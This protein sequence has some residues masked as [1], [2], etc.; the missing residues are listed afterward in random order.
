MIEEYYDAGGDHAHT[1]LGIEKEAFAGAAFNAAKTIIPRLATHAGKAWGASKAVAPAA[2]AVPTG[3][4]GRAWQATGGRVTEALGKAWRPTGGRVWNAGKTFAAPAGEA[5]E[6]G[7]ASGAGK[8]LGKPGSEMAAKLVKGVP[9]QAAKDA[10]IF[11]GLSAGLE[12]GVG[13]YAAEDGDRLKAFGEGAAHGAMSGAAMGGLMGG[14]GKGFR[15]L[16]S[17]SMQQAAGRQLAKPLAQ[18]R[19]KGFVGPL[20]PVQG[21]RLDAAGLAQRQTA[22][23]QKQM[24]RGFF[25]SVGD[26]ATGKGPINRATSAQNVAGGLG[27]FG[28]EWLAPMA[29]L[30]ASMGGGNPFKAETWGFG[31]TSANPAATDFSPETTAR[32]QAMYQRQGRLPPATAKT[33]E[34]IPGVDL[35]GIE[36]E[37]LKA[38]VRLLTTMGGGAATGIPV[39]MGID[40]L[41]KKP[42]YP[43]GGR[44]SL[45]ARTGQTLG[46][47][48]GVLG[49]HYAGQKLFPKKEDENDIEAKLEQIDFDKLMR[50]Y[51][52]R[53]A[54]QV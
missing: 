28:A 12:G 20:R 45:L 6:R 1:D 7:V 26:V 17:G 54:G 32:V 24:D 53:E 15:N 19:P 47:A 50:Y 38:P 8:V 33:A 16:R 2:K 3:A 14:F 46:T 41:R 30:P 48:A 21:P 43:A 37:Q 11:G 44:G 25:K 27:Q 29:V 23:A 40:A 35:L 51:K 52:K 13:A 4:M 31:D 36:Q 34:D 10:V 39:G 22:M 9:G 5:I 49:G 18:V 42:W